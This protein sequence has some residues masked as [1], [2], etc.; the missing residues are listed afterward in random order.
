MVIKF[1]YGPCETCAYSL[2]C[3]MRAHFNIN[4]CLNHVEHIIVNTISDTTN[5]ST[6]VPAKELTPL[7]QSKE[8][9]RKHCE[10]QTKPCFL[11]RDLENPFSEIETEL[12]DAEK[13]KKAVEILKKKKVNVWTLLTTKTVAAY[14][15]REVVVKPKR[16]LTEKEY[17]F[18]KE[19]F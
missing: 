18:L 2:C 19:V 3:Q 14:N 6:P 9:I 13:Y 10:N 1:G 5:P 4:G 17:D 8:I 15:F 12:N 11:M 16:K 7:E